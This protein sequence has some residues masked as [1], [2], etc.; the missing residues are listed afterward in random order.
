MSNPDELYEAAKAWAWLRHWSNGIT[1]NPPSPEACATAL[2]EYD[3]Q[4]RK[5]IPDGLIDEVAAGL[6]PVL[7][8][9]VR[10]AVRAEMAGERR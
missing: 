5:P 9:L 10:E 7:R 3:K 8:D 6:A 2:A 4:L 1:T